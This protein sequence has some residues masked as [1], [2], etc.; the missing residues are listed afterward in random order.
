M[1]AKLAREKSSK[2]PRAQI[3]SVGRGGPNP[4]IMRTSQLELLVD[5]VNSTLMDFQPINL[6]NTGG[7]NPA[8]MGWAGWEELRSEKLP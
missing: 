2:I 6:Y 8:A 7:S 1:Q 3:S 4:E 5:C